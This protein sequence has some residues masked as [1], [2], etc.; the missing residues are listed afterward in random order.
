MSKGIASWRV[1]NIAPPECIYFGGVFYFK[2]VKMELFELKNIEHKTCLTCK[3]RQRW[4]CNSKIIQ[5]CG[6][7]KSKRT[8]N[9]LL[10]IRCKDIACILYKNE[11]E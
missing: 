6:A 10:K 9:G 5:Y 1:R 11:K 3:H 7:R 2:R 8:E 4:Q